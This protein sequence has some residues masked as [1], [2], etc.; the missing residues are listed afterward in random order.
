MEITEGAAEWRPVIG[1]EGRYEV[2]D[3]GVISSLSNYR[4]SSGGPL[5]PW[6]NSKG[7]QYVTLRDA[8]GGKR[9]QAVH[10]IV[11][12]AFVEL[13]PSGKQ[14]AHGDGNP[15]NNRVGNLRWATSKENIADRTRHGRTAQ[16][17]A[18]AASKLDRH[19]VKTI[20]RMKDCGFSAYETAR[21]AC[22]NPSTIDRIWAGETWKHV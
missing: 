16:G 14:V 1:Y 20:K 5:A 2:S 10:R 11:L 7:Y 13:R 21:L 6:A 17:E 8:A 19:A 3:E 4:S 18:N 9:A 22:V 15:A 12:E